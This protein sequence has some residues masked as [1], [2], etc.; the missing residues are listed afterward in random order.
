MTKHVLPAKIDP[1][2]FARSNRQVE[3]SLGLAAM[4]RLLEFLASVDGQAEFKLD[5][6]LDEENFV[7]I[8]VNTKASLPMI[9]Q[10]CL[11]PFE[12]EVKVYSELS[13]V[14]HESKIKSLP[15]RYDAWPLSA[16]MTVSPAEIIEEEL[17]LSLPRVAMHDE[18]E[19]P[20]GRVATVTES[21]EQQAKH[22]P[23]AILKKL[24]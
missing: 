9:C 1:A 21:V 20:S 24:K 19:C 15:D 16:E 13:P 14:T 5:F 10:R 6:S 22:K 17:I 11:Q 2:N 23:F 4:P 8:G 12:Y 18:A 3:G 7:V